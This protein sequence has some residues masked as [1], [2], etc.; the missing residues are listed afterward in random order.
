MNVHPAQTFS[1]T[2]SQLFRPKVTKRLTC[3][4]SI[5]K[6]KRWETR[7]SFWATPRVADWFGGRPTAS[8]SSFL[9][10][11]WMNNAWQI[12]INQWNWH[13]YW[14][15]TLLVQ[16]GWSFGFRTQ[17][18]I[19][20]VSFMGWFWFGP[21]SF[22]TEEPTRRRRRDSER[23]ERQNQSLWTRDK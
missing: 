11:F 13:C 2:I 5:L 18:H 9:S 22:P 1:Q 19:A 10:K 6:W 17:I 23:N 15:I 16:E 14:D 8:S 20:S 4:A 7:W 3:S 12:Y 21:C